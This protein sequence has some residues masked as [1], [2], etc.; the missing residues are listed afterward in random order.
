MA[1]R[2]KTGGS[3]VRFTSWNV[4]GLNGPVKRGKI[5]S[6]IKNLKTDIAFLQ[7]THLRSSDQLRLKKHWVGQI[8]HSSFNTKARG[9]AVRMHKRIQFTSSSFISDPQ[10]RYVI[11]SGQLFHIPVLLVNIYAPNW[12][13]GFVQRVVCQLP[14]LN[15]RLLILGGDFNCVMDPNLD[16]SNPKVLYSL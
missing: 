5:L 14:D 3:A 8:F 12:D 2:A 11:V 1:V 15:T 9:T 6:H 13:A 7:E 10:G 4:K 16:R